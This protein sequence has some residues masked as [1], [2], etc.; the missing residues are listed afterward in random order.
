MSRKIT[1]TIQARL[2]S[3]RLPGKVLKPILGRPMIA[4]QIERIQQ[5][6][7]IDEVVIATSTAPENDALARLAAEMGIGCFRGSEDDV[8]GRV[9][10]ALRA[11]AADLHVEFQ[12][13]NPMPD[14]LLVDAIV[15]FFLKHADDYDYVTNSMKTTYPP[16]AEV[17][18]Y[19]AAVLYDA[20]RHATDAKLREHVG[21]HI[22][23]HP[24]RYR[25][26][27]LEAPAWLRCPDLHLEVDT[28]EDFEVVNAIF[29]A[30]YP[31]NPGFSLQQ[32]IAFATSSGLG[33]KNKDVARRWQA[34]RED[35]PSA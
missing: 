33:E 11:S 1:A 10:G 21:I 5:S 9:A 35:A 15:G 27:N 23:Q 13:D 24:E 19:P 18:V 17:S 26:R 3:S 32:A 29:E 28:D 31:A 8:L 25:I 30:L 34:F 22:Y 20:E 12:G 4:R 2:G 7:L 14:A 16:G 6:R